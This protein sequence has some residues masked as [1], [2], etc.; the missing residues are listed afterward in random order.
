MAVDVLHEISP[1]ILIR[2]VL[3]TTV[4]EVRIS[5]LRCTLS[6]L[7]SSVIEDAMESKDSLLPLEES[8][9]NSRLLK[10]L[11]RS[12]FCMD[13]R[14][15]LILS[16]SSSAMHKAARLR[17]FVFVYWLVSRLKWLRYSCTKRVFIEAR[18]Q[19][20]VSVNFN[21][22]PL[23]KTLQLRNKLEKG[24]ATL[25]W[26]SSVMYSPHTFQLIADSVLTSRR[27][28]WCCEVSGT[29]NFFWYY[30]LFFTQ[31][32]LNFESDDYHKEWPFK[33]ELQW[34]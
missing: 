29:K 1:S 8:V 5:K 32:V 6:K 27:A 16:S 7:C 15:E 13:S 25:D 11:P 2:G 17:S 14:F 4:S 26:N 19:N 9:S 22:G 21:K 12:T 33:L 20:S 23:S 3:Y 24:K 18:F 30:R 31:Q 28:M 10:L 34:L